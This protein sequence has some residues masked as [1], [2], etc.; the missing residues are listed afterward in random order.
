MKQ[1]KLWLT[2]AII[3]CG[4]TVLTSY[5]NND[6]PD[7]LTQADKVEAQLQ[8]MTLSEKVG[9]LFFVR[10]ESLDTTI[11]FNLPNRIDGSLRRVRCRDIFANIHQ[12]HPRHRECPGHILHRSHDQHIVLIE[13]RQNSGINTIYV[14]L[15]LGINQVNAISDHHATVLSCGRLELYIKAIKDQLTAIDLRP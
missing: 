15:H 3:I 9:Q 11:H 10:P 7:S 14:F 5:T 8:K 13:I 6:V 1:T 12:Q 4:A 2:A